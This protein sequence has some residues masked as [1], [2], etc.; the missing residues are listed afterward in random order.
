MITIISQVII[1]VLIATTG[2]AL[3]RLFLNFRKSKK[4]L[5]DLNSATKQLK[6]ENLIETHEVVRQILGQNGDDDYL[7]KNWREFE[8]SLV[9]TPD[10]VE[11]TLD[12]QHFF[13]TNILAK[14]V[15]ENSFYE[16]L[17]QF[18]VGVGVLGTFAGLAY[19]L[20]GINL[21]SDDIEILKQGIE[22]LVNGASVAFKSSLYGIFLSLIFSFFHNICKNF[23]SKKINEF[24]L[25][26][27]FIYPRTNPEKS[28]IH[29]RDFSK[30]TSNLLGSLSET[31]GNK[32]QDVVR[33]VSS[34]ISKGIQESITPYMAEITK[35][36]MSSSESV[37]DEM[38]DEFLSK[39][40][41]AG[42]AQQKLILEVNQEIQNALIEF[43]KDF[44]GQV[45]ELKD[46][47]QNLNESYHFI[48]EKLI[49]QFDKVISEFAK[50]IEG[51]KEEQSEFID[52]LKK[53]KETIEKLEEVSTDLATIMN[54]IQGLITNSLGAYRQATDNL[55]LVY[56]SNNQASEKLIEVSN[57][58]AA[59]LEALENQY[60]GMQETIQKTINSIQNELET[61]LKGYFT[62]VEDQTTQRLR[63]W[64]NQTTS[65]STAMLNVTT[66]LNSLVKEIRET[67]ES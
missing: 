26:L 12:A 59:P 61:T 13:N 32:L 15:F 7:F 17:P 31:L 20:S 56:E 6:K 19:G 58:F 48:E 67:N 63:E 62:Q 39:V 14:N 52:E 21:S 8:E 65:F 10:S 1:I 60:Q 53:Q 36:A 34:E 46:V 3:F 35:K 28:L 27:N 11:N 23:L 38:M 55:E 41:M 43:R 29:I 51:Y 57:S 33:E 22:T 24:Q 44:T 50:A 18:L 45:I 64:N 54:E 9:I 16:N 49:T 25:K 2:I 30:E 66:Q 40:S 47:I 37:L 4:Y 5:K 42:E